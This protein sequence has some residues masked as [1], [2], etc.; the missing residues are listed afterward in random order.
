MELT[1]QII[2]ANEMFD[3]RGVEMSKFKS[4]CIFTTLA[5]LV[6]LMSAKSEAANVTARA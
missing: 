3:L 2:I 6:L 5:S 1:S 4:A